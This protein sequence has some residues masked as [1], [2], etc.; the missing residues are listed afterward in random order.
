MQAL[1]VSQELST[2]ESL[3]NFKGKL[4]RLHNG[5]SSTGFLKSA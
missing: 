3:D 5:G 2:A 4:Q 1:K